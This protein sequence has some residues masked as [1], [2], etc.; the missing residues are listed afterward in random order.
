MGVVIHGL[1]LHDCGFVLGDV[2]IG[3]SQDISENFLIV[4]AGVL[5]FLRG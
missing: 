5:R 2:D 4:G 1:G 3:A